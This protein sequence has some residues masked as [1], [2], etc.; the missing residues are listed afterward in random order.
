MPGQLDGLTMHVAAGE[1]VGVAGLAGRRARGRARRWCAAGAVP[2]PEPGAAARATSSPGRCG[3]PT[4]HGVGFVPRR[5]EGRGADARPDACGRTSRR[6]RWLG[7]GAAA[8]V[9]Q[10]TRRQRQPGRGAGRSGCGSGVTPTRRVGRP[11]RRQPAEGRLRQV[12]GRRSERGRPRRPDPG[13]RRRRHAPR[14]TAW[15]GEL[16]AQGSVV[17]IAS[18]DLAELVELCDRVA[19]ASSAG[20]SSTPRGER[21]DQRSLSTAMNAGFAAGE[22]AI[23]RRRRRR[24]SRRSGAQCSA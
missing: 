14:C 20:G 15:S 6:S 2:R 7:L 13:C 8:A 17:L 4:A 21:L 24:R 23:D 22:V 3:T 9:W 10:R 18:T 1:I 12:D 11:V 19:G 5:P 16:A